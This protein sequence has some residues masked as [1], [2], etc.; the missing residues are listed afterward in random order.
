MQECCTTAVRSEVGK[1]DE[2][3][4]R[5]LRDVLEKITKEIENILGKT[6]VFEKT[7]EKLGWGIVKRDANIQQ[8]S[9]S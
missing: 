2:S 3:A 7:R 8:R 4:E 5:R 9:R 1:L 6:S